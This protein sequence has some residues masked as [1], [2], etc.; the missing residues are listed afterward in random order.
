[1]P[2]YPLDASLTL[3]AAAP[4]WLSAHQQYIQPNTLRNYRSSICLLTAAMGEVLLKDIS[5]EHIRT[6]QAQRS[7]NAGSYLVNGEVSVLQMI[8]KHAGEWS[9]IRESLQTVSGSGPGG[10]PFV[11]PRRRDPVARGCVHQTEVAFGRTLHDGHAVDHDGLWRAA[12]PATP[13]RRYKEAIHHCPRG[14]EESF[15]SSHYSAQCSG[16]RVDDLDPRALEKVGWR[17]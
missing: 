2:L 15:P 9:R 12:A 17:Q 4:Q 8:L 13:R 11:D 6:Y 3:S 5:I 7:K 16:I 10:R 1:M 14:S